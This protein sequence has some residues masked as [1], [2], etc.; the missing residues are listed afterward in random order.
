MK[1][2]FLLIAVAFIATITPSVSFAD[3]GSDQESIQNCTA[4]SKVV[5]PDIP[6]NGDPIVKSSSKSPVKSGFG[7]GGGV[8]SNSKSSIKYGTH[9]SN[10]NFSKKKYHK[11]LSTYKRKQFFNKI[12]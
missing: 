3:N 5:C 11:I 2:L 10:N 4:V 1:K 9:K 12:F 6:G 7:I 8:Q